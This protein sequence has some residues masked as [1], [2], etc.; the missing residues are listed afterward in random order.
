[1][2]GDF[3][4]NNTFKDFTYVVA[5]DADGLNDL[6]IVDTASPGNVGFAVDLVGVVDWVC[7]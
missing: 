7:A 3:T 1:M 2:T 6:R 5:S 4:A